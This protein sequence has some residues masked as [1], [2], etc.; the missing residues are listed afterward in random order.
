MLHSREQVRSFSEYVAQ[1]DSS[2]ACVAYGHVCLTVL[3]AE[4][5]AILAEADAVAVE[6]DTITIMC[7]LPRSPSFPALHVISDVGGCSWG[8]HQQQRQC[9][10]HGAQPHRE[11]RRPSRVAHHPT[12]VARR[13]VALKASC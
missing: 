6:A 11:Q 4:R 2:K 9:E 5:A 7:Y 3:A 8:Q 13:R 12:S 1:W 10:T